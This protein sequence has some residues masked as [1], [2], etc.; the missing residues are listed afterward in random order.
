MWNAAVAKAA[1]VQ[2]EGPAGWMKREVV[3][4]LAQS[5]RRCFITLRQGFPAPAVPVRNEP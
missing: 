4:S 1:E 3:V 5:L 2:A